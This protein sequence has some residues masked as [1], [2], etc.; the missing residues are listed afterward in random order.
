MSVTRLFDLLKYQLENFPQHA[1]VNSRQED[2]SWRSYSSAE[3]ADTAEKAAAADVAHDG[4]GADPVAQPGHR[5]GPGGAAGRAGSTSWR[6]A[7][8][9]G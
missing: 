8:P 1:S 4:A 9:A 3:I 6:S 7:T 2:G 5:D